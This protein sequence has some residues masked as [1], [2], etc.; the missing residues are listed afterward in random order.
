MLSVERTSIKLVHWIKLWFTKAQWKTCKFF[1]LLVLYNYTGTH[2]N[3]LTDT[4][5]MFQWVHWRAWKVTE[6]P[7]L[8]LAHTK[9]SIP[10]IVWI[11]IYKNLRATWSCPL[12]MHILGLP[13]LTLSLKGA[14][15][16]NHLWWFRVLMLLRYSTALLEAIYFPFFPK[17]PIW[18]QHS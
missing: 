8:L 3:T 4:Q 10:D 7:Q 5:K 12:Q 9:T 1:S 16:K 2:I 17:T 15:Q 6:A 14:C 11:M 13:I 18:V